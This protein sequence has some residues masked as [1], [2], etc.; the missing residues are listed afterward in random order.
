VEREKSDAIPNKQ[1]TNQAQEGLNQLREMPSLLQVQPGISL[2]ALRTTGAEKGEIM[3][4]QSSLSEG[5]Q[6]F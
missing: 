1:E 5:G 3:S 4:E 6:L 2:E